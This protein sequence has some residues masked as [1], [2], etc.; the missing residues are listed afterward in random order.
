M[1]NT[2]N[3]RINPLEYAPSLEL[4]IVNKPPPTHLTMSVWE[5]VFAL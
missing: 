1:L 3:P 4:Q 5:Y 2:V